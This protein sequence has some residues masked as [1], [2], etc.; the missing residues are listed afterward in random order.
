MWLFLKTDCLF[1]F[2]HQVDPHDGL[3]RGICIDCERRIVD[4]YML[5][6]LA[7]RSNN[8]LIALRDKHI[9]GSSPTDEERCEVEQMVGSNEEIEIIVLP[10]KSTGNENVELYDVL[11][12]RRSTTNRRNSVE[13]TTDEYDMN[14][15]PHKKGTVVQ[16]SAS[17]VTD[18]TTT[19]DEDAEDDEN[20]EDGVSFLL[21]LQQNNTDETAADADVIDTINQSDKGP[22]KRRSCVDPTDRQSEADSNATTGNSGNR[23]HLCNVCDKTFMRKSNLIDHLRL[24]ANVRP[25]ECEVCK[26]TFVQIGNLR[27]HMRVHTKERPYK[28]T[29]CNKTYNQSGAL[30]VHLRAHTNERNYKCSYCN[31]GFTNSSDRNKHQR[32]HDQSTQI[33]CHLCGNR[34]FAQRVNYKLHMR[35]YHPDQWPATDE[36]EAPTNAPKK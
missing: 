5:R 3:P 29:L 19:A 30:K 36:T 24:H 34:K 4:A 6:S 22:R 27:A 31:K 32:V 21:Q 15:E 26:Q 35:R 33:E 18:T 14:Y 11:H 13:C 20:E 28:C 8:D 16:I 12:Q 10:R 23:R 25:H 9:S 17:I 2:V 7:C 1:G